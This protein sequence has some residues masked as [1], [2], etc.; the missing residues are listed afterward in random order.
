MSG[1]RI[2]FHKCDLI[3]IKVEEQEAKLFSQSCVVG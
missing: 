2:N 1:M 3:S